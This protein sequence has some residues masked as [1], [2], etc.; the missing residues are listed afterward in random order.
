MEHITDLLVKWT[1]LVHILLCLITLAGCRWSTERRGDC[2][3]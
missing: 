3:V 1:V 2:G